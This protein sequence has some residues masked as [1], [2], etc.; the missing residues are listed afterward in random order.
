MVQRAPTE[1]YSRERTFQRLQNLDLH[2]ARL[3]V[4]QRLE[5]KPET[6]ERLVCL[7]DRITSEKRRLIDLVA[8]DGKTGSR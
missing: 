5:L 2:E 8:S 3:R 7:L 6:R 4:I 1:V